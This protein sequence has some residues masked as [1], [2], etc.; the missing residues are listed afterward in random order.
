MIEKLPHQLSG[1]QFVDLVKKEIGE[2]STQLSQVTLTSLSKA[3]G[4]SA[5]YLRILVAQDDPNP[6]VLTMRAVLFTLG[7]KIDSPDQDVVPMLK[8]KGV[9]DPALHRTEN[10]QRGAA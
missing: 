7:Y 6:S 10:N 1:R 4:L 2:R 9:Y 5:S 3:S 8:R